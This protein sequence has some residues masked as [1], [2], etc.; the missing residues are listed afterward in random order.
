MLVRN[1][2]LTGSDYLS[3]YQM[4]VSQT[5]SGADLEIQKGFLS[6]DLRR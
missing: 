5:K 4:L 2:T 1:N 6:V 3:M